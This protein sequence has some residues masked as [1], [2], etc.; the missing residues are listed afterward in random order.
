MIE[1]HCIPCLLVEAVICDHRRSLVHDQCSVML[2]SIRAGKDVT[3]INRC[4]FSY[5]MDT[6]RH[7]LLKV[8]EGLEGWMMDRAEDKEI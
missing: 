5:Q 6:F 7:E 1:N 2:L 8:Q 3:E 4:L